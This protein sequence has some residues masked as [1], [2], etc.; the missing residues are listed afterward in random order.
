MVE[1]AAA[2]GVPRLE[3]AV[4]AARQPHEANPEVIWYDNFDIDRLSTYLEPKAGSPDARRSADEG[5]GGHGA[6]ME[7]FYAQGS[8]G[9]GNRKLVFGDCPFGKPLR[10][11]ERFTDVYWRI[12]VKHQRGWQG[13]PAK[14]SRA[15][16][17]VSAAWNQAFISHVWS[18]G[19]PLT[20]DPASGVQGGQVVTTKYND[21]DHL[22]WLGNRP[23]GRFLLH[24]TAESGRWVCI[25]SRVRLNTPGQED[26]LAT[27]WV[28]G[29]L[30]SSRAN[31]DFCGTYTGRGAA[32]NAIFLEAY[33]NDGSPADQYRWYDDFVVSTHPI[34]PLTADPN[35]T[36][37][38]QPDPEC[39]RW[40]AQIAADPQGAG[41]V[42][43]SGLLLG[44]DRRVTVTAESGGF[45]GLAA[46]QSALPAGPM[47]FGRVRQRD[48]TGEWSAWSGWHQ[49]F[50]VASGV[51]PTQARVGMGGGFP[52]LVVQLLGEAAAGYA[53]EATTDFDQWSVVAQ[54]G[55]PTGWNEWP[56]PNAGSPAARFFR[57]RKLPGS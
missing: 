50:W 4:L 40:E 12:Y 3:S 43:A 54:V 26:G 28:D 31:L 17:F 41:L 23:V 16:G 57:A 30:D 35:P 42:W 11:G 49:P 19:L 22:R 46:G 32:V 53:L 7:C 51:G 38:R 1:L 37:I 33:W 5:L 14:L 45:V 13:S 34:G 15:T 24:A 56:V 48:A 27:L 36:L 25:E 18:A 52:A 10:S 8:R 29:V 20:L 21:F 47:Y 39:H 2:P 6:A 55:S 9:V 44:A